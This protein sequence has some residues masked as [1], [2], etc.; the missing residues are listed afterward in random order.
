MVII[1]KTDN[2]TITDNDFIEWI[3][4]K[5]EILFKNEDFG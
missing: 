4:L 2:L 3:D 5:G 1:N